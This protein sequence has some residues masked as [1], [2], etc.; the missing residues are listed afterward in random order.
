VLTSN[1]AVIGKV[2]GGDDVPQ[3]NAKAASDNANGPGDGVPKLPV[4][5]TNL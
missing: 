3:K 1:Y 5:V 2:T 4:K